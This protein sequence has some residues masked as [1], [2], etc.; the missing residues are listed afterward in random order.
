[1]HPKAIISGGILEEECSE[2]L[3]QFFI[4]KRGLN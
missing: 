1:L 2:I 3:K 4:Q